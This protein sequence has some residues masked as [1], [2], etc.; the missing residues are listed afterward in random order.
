MPSNSIASASI[1]LGSLPR[2][3]LQAHPCLPES[4]LGI[5]SPRSRRAY[6]LFIHRDSVQSVRLTIVPSKAIPISRGPCAATPQ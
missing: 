1:H 3:V 6:K 4:T 2:P 5:Y